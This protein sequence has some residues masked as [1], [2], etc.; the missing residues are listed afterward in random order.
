MPVTRL[1]STQHWKR[2]QLAAESESFHGLPDTTGRQ[3]KVIVRGIPF[4]G[5]LSCWGAETPMG[6]REQI[7][8]KWK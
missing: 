1:L 6:P 8:W 5:Q 7:K 2:A 4:V 3:N